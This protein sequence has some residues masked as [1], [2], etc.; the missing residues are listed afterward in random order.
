[1]SEISFPI[2]DL[3]RRKTQTALT[4]LSLTIAI[5]ATIFLV[6][7]GGSLGFEITFL[8]RGTINKRIL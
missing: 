8:A 3:T 5:A 7:F 6:I 1:M 2:K 4:V